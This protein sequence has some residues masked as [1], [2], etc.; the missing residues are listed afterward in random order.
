MNITSL[1]ENTSTHPDI[2]CEHGLSLYI[3]TSS[4][5]ILFDTG[6]SSLFAE[7][8][9]KLGIDLGKVDLAILSHGHYDH[10]GGLKTFLSLNDHAPLYIRKE[11]FGPYYSQREDG[12][13]HYIGIDTELLSSSRLILTGALTP[14]AEGI[15]LFSRVE[16]TEFVPTGNQSLYRKEGDSYLPDSFTH[17]QYLLIE[18]GETRLLIS[19]CS[20]RGIVN[21]V[22]SAT[23]HWCKPPTH[24]IGG[25]HLYNHRTGE[26]ETPEV[27]D[28]IATLLLATKARYYTCHC[29]GEENYRYLKTK[30]E[31]HIAYLAGGDVLTC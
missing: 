1:L 5:N 21:I 10:A 11:A 23:E 24:V 6:S 26:P 14:I 3:E 2:A 29:T 9:K 30:M 18:E 17:E 12:R 27:L 22:K 25:F 8:A 28:A 20:H 4:K 31:D 19:G 7:N 15:S 13:Y 16:G